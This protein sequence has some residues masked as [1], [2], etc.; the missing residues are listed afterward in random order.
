MIEARHAFENY[1]SSQPAAKPMLVEHQFTVFCSVVE[2]GGEGEWDALR[3]R[4]PRVKDSAERRNIILSL[5]CTKS[6]ETI[7]R[8][9][10]EFS[11][12]RFNMVPLIFAEAARHGKLWR[13]RAAEYVLTN[14]Q[15]LKM[16][17]PRRFQDILTCV[18]KYI[19]SDDELS[20]V[21]MLLRRHRWSLLRYSSVFDSIEEAAKK[22]M[23]WVDAH[24]DEVTRWLKRDVAEFILDDQVMH[25]NGTL[26]GIGNGTRDEEESGSLEIHGSEDYGEIGVYSGRLKDRGIH[27]STRSGMG[28]VEDNKLSRTSDAAV[29]RPDNREYDQ[30]HKEI[31][32]TKADLDGST[33]MVS[34][35]LDVAGCTS[36]SSSRSDSRDAT[37]A[38]RGNGV[39]TNVTVNTSA[40][41]RE[42]ETPIEIRAK[43]DGPGKESPQSY[44]ETLQGGEHRMD[45]REN[46]DGTK[47]NSSAYVDEG[48]I[49]LMSRAGRSINIS[50]TPEKTPHAAV[51]YNPTVF[52]GANNAPTLTGQSQVLANSASRNMGGSFLNTT[53]HAGSEDAE[54]KIPV[55]GSTVADLND[56][57]TEG[58]RHQSHQLAGTDVKKTADASKSGY[59]AVDTST[60]EDEPANTEKAAKV[61]ATSSLTKI[62]VAN[63]AAEGIS[64]PNAALAS[65]ATDTLNTAE[66]THAADGTSMP[67]KA[68]IAS[69]SAGIAPRDSSSGPGQRRDDVDGEDASNDYSFTDDYE[70]SGDSEYA[71][72]EGSGQG[73]DMTL[74]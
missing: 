40:G 2:E 28:K 65:K 11:A 35:D 64:A 36:E 48:N 26:S 67:L 17:F 29:N 61:I 72:N 69:D 66:G 21:N 34:M 70:E 27:T 5:G 12:P 8:Y 59:A 60:T 3:L 37:L 19:S 45:T 38:S 14:W 20:D 7:M 13:V 30:H 32:G 73:K 46:A 56:V 9:F 50:A 15:Q 22:N 71:V 57:S 16:T 43:D 24:L 4:L 74:R 58:N 41:F 62:V 55:E 18:F 51:Q 53:E 68:G 42:S 23:R 49:S 25:G 6:H 47:E 63:G 44:P 52:L 33:L 54:N 1:K 39:A 10:E 31:A